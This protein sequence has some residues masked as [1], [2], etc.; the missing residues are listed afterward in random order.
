MFYAQNAE[1]KVNEEKYLPY[2]RAAEAKYGIPSPLLQRLLYQESHFRTDIIDGSTQSAVGAVG[3]AQFMPSTAREY[4]I[5]PT[6]PISSIDAAGHYLSVLY[7]M[8]NS[9]SEAVMA[10]NWGPGNVRHWRASGVGARGQPVPKETLDY[11]VQ[12]TTDS[13]VA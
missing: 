4:N 9:W 8:F 6:D 1:T 12:I 13:G 10:Y 11:V 3:I 5:D 7:E 2:I